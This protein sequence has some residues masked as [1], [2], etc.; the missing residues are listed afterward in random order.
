MN[1]DINNILNAHNYE[2]ICDY[3]FLPAYGKNLPSD[4][5]TKSGNIFCKTDFVLDLFSKLSNSQGNYNL[6][7][8]HSDYPITKEL[9]NKKPKCIKT[10][11]GTNIKHKAPDL[12]PIPIGVNNDYMTG[13]PNAKD[14]HDRTFKTFDSKENKIYFNFNI[15]TRF[16]QRFHLKQKFLN[17]KGYVVEEN[18]LTKGEYLEKINSYKYVACPWGN[19]LDTHRLWEAIYSN[20][21]PIVKKHYAFSKFQ[22]LPIIFVK[23]Y[24]MLKLENLMI[25]N[26]DMNLTNT[27]ADFSYWMKYIKGIKN[28]NFIPNKNNIVLQINENNFYRKFLKN[29]KIKQRYKKIRY[30]IFRVYKYL[31][32][33]LIYRKA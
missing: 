15:N 17:K 9:F 23:N 16:L 4:I 7:T 30:F 31:L 22:D 25:K 13:Y 32:T 21:I 19:G 29:R 3:T 2:L 6:I 27:T 28:K 26:T 24:N 8:H 5:N 10:W 11:F 1:F 18:T 20:S 12:I 14:F 33:L